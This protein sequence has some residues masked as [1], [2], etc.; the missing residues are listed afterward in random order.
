ML[1][2]GD[3]MGRFLL[4]STVVMLLPQRPLQF[5]PRLGAGRAPSAWA[6]RW[7]SAPAEGQAQ[8]YSGK[9]PSAYMISSTAFGRPMPPNQR[10]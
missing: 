2:Q 9:R 4:G 6:R 7:H 1:Q 5:N 3:E 8:A 10:P